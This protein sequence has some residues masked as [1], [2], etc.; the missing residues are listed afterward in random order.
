M[1]IEKNYQRFHQGQPTFLEFSVNK[2]LLLRNFPR[3]LSHLSASLAGTTAV[4]LTI[5]VSCDVFTEILFLLSPP[6]TRNEMN[7]HKNCSRL[8]YNYTTIIVT[9][10]EKQ[11]HTRSENLVLVDARAFPQTRETLELNT[12]HGWGKCSREIATS[13][14]FMSCRRFI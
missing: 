13:F 5:L 2:Q 3:D 6:A 8:D 10:R 14:W 7:R 4:S 9:F 1:K 11:S 12:G